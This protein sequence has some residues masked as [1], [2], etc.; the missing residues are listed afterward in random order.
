MTIYSLDI[1]LSR[2]GTN[3]LF[4]VQFYL[5]LLALHTDFS[6]GRSGGLLFPSLKE[7]FTV[8]CDPQQI[9]GFG[10][11]NKAEVAVFLEFSC[12]FD[13]PRDVGNLISG[14]SAFS[15]S[16]LN[17][18]KFMVHLRL[19]PGLEN[20]EHYFARVWDECQPM[21]WAP[22]ANQMG[23]GRS[24][25]L[26]SMQTAA[27]RSLRQGWQWCSLLPQDLDWAVGGCGEGSGARQDTAPQ[28]FS[29]GGLHGKCGIQ[30]L[31]HSLPD[32]CHFPDS[33]LH[34]LTKVAPWEL[35]A[36]G[37]GPLEHWLMTEQDH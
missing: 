1:L 6:G 37:W 21:S 3:F 11:V 5:L 8:C 26:H 22:Q 14:S 16:N 4:H 31:A 36:C 30:L 29:G 33:W 25:R 24:H 32:D 23:R 17:T 13:D 2:F 28:P 9:K 19:K 35:V 10:I 7:C 27:T 34:P 20:F 15:K 12:F 18:W